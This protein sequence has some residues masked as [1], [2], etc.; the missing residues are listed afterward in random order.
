MRRNGFA[1][2]LHRN[3]LCSHF[4]DQA[5]WD[6]AIATV[7]LLKNFMQLH[8]LL[9]FNKGLSHV[10]TWNVCGKNTDG[11]GNCSRLI[12]VYEGV[13]L[14]YLQLLQCSPFS[15]TMTHLKTTIKWMNQ[16]KRKLQRLEAYGFIA[17]ARKGTPLLG[18]SWI[19]IWYFV[20]HGKARQITPICVTWFNHQRDVD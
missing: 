9:I 11:F 6:F 18:L 12:F 16:M 15:C 7:I 1:N 10:S 17:I 20:L 3:L 13:V 14:N 5:H 8:S 19:I 2:D 4:T